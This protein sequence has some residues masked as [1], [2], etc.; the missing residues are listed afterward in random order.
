MKLK[1]LILLVQLSVTVQALSDNQRN[2]SD[3]KLFIEKYFVN[4]K[5]I[6]IFTGMCQTE[7]GLSI[8]WITKNLSEHKSVLI[9]TRNGSDEEN[10]TFFPNFGYVTVTRVMDRNF[11]EQL[12]MIRNNGRWLVVFDRHLNEF[13]EELIKLAWD[14]HKILHLVVL[15]FDSVEG[16]YVVLYYDPFRGVRHKRCLMDVK[17]IIQT[18]DSK[19]RN[20]NGYGLHTYME[21]PALTYANP[22][23]D[24]RGQLLKYRGIDGEVLEAIRHSMNFEVKFLSDLPDTA[25]IEKR[26]ELISQLVV[27]RKVH[28]ISD[29]RFLNRSGILGAYPLSPLDVTYIVCALPVRHEQQIINIFWGFLDVSGTVL[30]YITTGI[31]VVA[32][33][34]T[35]KSS[36]ES[37]FKYFLDIIGIEFNI[38]R[39]L[40]NYIS[41]SSRLV[42][43]SL[44][45]LNLTI[46]ATFQANI[47]SQLNVASK[48]RQINTLNDLIRENVKIFTLSPFY[49]ILKGN[50]TEIP[51]SD[52]IQSRL[53]SHFIY[54]DKFSNPVLIER[55]A[56]GEVAL[57]TGT[58][59]RK[60]QA[61]YV[62]AHYVNKET[63][64]SSI[65]LVSEPVLVYPMAIHMPAWSPFI[66]VMNEMLIRVLE[67][68]FFQKGYNDADQ[69]IWLQRLKTYKSLD[70][71]AL[72]PKP[73]TCEHLSLAF[74]LY[75]VMMG[76]AFVAF[77]LEII[78]YKL[79]Q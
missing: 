57:N 7:C 18:I 4:Q 63:G 72:E 61:L 58:L 1:S 59:I 25:A 22:V 13:D 76:L 36:P 41:I 62:Q 11:L 79:V 51:P 3:V 74:V 64:V 6:K 26:S 34:L 60:Y 44:F 56:R 29:A 17:S 67:M 55:M 5:I 38:S 78:Y 2:K 42:L 71:E 46:V 20:L 24:E 70:D 53:L 48:A 32:L 40:Q 28:L 9:Y 37:N 52:T 47:T 73:I 65:H 35:M 16:N 15:V 33:C 75:G 14:M 43:T 68:G 69:L 27:E 19:I 8:N 54:N 31:F 66:P 50:D 30:F 12:S 49:R 39:S 21:S 77:I 10:L 45:I 23:Y